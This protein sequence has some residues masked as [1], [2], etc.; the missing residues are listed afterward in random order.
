M[1][2]RIAAPQCAISLQPETGKG[3]GRRSTPAAKGYL[4]SDIFMS[5]ARA[6][7]RNASIFTSA[8]KACP[9]TPTS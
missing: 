1:N 7:P 6:C 3:A 5:A 4:G 9:L 2:Y 8:V